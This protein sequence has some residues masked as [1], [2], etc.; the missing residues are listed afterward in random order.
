MP[1]KT[2]PAILQLKIS[3]QGIRPLIWRR[4]EVPSQT[5]L[6]QLHRLLQ[7]VM[8]GKTTTCMN[9]GLREGPMGSPTRKIIILAETSS[10]SAGPEWVS[11]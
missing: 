11:F 7:I 6:P 5:T 1:E 10:T 2:S 3:V 8:G 9:S 4:I